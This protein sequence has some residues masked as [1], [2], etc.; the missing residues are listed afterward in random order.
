M[1]RGRRALTAIMTA[2]LLGLGLSGPDHDASATAYQADE[3]RARLRRPY[4]RRGRQ[5]DRGAERQA[6]PRPRRHGD[7]GA[8]GVFRFRGPGGHELARPCV[9]LESP[10]PVPF[11]EAIDRLAEASRLAYRLGDSSAVRRPAW[12]SRGTVR[13]PARPAMPGRSG[14]ACSGSTSTTTSS[15]SAGPW[16]RFFPSGESVPGDAADLASAPKDGGPLYAELHAGRR[17]RPGL[18]PRRAV[19]GAGGR[20]RGRE[21]AP[22]P[23]RGRRHGRRSGPSRPS[24]AR[25]PRSCGSR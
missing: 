9:T 21:A 12:R 3:D 8:V 2:A 11:W 22:G 6:C 5:G 23:R 24:M 10:G 16:V 19:E 7:E 15:S 20:G 25:L 14:S 13:P 17:A 1:K 4:G 18:P